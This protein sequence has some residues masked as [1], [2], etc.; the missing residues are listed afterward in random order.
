MT[1]TPT[2]E[3][4]YSRGWRDADVKKEAERIADVFDRDADHVRTMRETVAILRRGLG[5]VAA[6]T[7]HDAANRCASEFFNALD[8]LAQRLSEDASERRRAARGEQP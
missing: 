1:I 6:V 2:Y 5:Q 4:G 8:K 3:E 7:E